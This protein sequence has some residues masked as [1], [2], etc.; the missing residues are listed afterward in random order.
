M[1]ADRG[2]YAQDTWTIDRLTVN[3]GVRF[4]QFQ[5]GNDTYRAGAGIQRRPVHRRAS[6]STAQD[7]KPFWND[8][9]PRFSVVYDLFG[10]ARTALKFSVNRFMK[11]YTNGFA[12]RYHPIS[13]QADT[14]DWLDCALHPGIHG[15]GAARC[16]TAAEF[17]ALGM[18][19]YTATNG[20]Y[21]AQDHEIGTSAPTPRSS[22]AASWR[23]WACGRPRPAAGV[24]RRVDRQHPARDS[25]RGSR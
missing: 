13:L 12:R 16:A 11:P 21:I 8:I 19:D 10:D 1:R 7:Q 18:P 14:R 6:C 3:A 20:D 4:E 23:R 9:A 17:A 15:G 25:P 24:Q 5:S 2:I 22:P